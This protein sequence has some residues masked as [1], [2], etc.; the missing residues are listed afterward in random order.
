[1]GRYLILLV[2]VAAFPLTPHPLVGQDQV[3]YESDFEGIVGQEWSTSTT[4]QGKTSH[5]GISGRR[6]LSIWH[7][8]HKRYIERIVS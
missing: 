2:V 8:A 6:Q 4:A 5:N 3:V 7:P 1:M